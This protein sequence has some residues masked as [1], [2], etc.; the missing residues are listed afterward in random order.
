MSCTYQ[1]MVNNA[2]GTRDAAIGGKSSS[3]VLDV[4]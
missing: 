4:E 3:I 1:M 2:C